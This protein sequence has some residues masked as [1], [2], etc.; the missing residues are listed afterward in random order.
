M[1]TRGAE[2]G[3]E[4]GWEGRGGEG[5]KKVVDTFQKTLAEGDVIRERILI[6]LSLLQTQLLSEFFACLPS[7]LSKFSRSVFEGL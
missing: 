2:N 1:V 5:R 7:P 3:R 4:M 6:K